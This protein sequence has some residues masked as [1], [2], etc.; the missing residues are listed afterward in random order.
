[1]LRLNGLL[2]PLLFGQ[3]IVFFLLLPMRTP[4]DMESE[5]QFSS[6]TESGLFMSR[7]ERGAIAAQ[8]R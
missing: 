2:E 3:Q 4:P 7:K 5:R 1:M 8:V 6:P